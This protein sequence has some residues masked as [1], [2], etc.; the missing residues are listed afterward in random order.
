MGQLLAIALVLV[1]LG[2]VLV[3]LAYRGRRKRGLGSGETIAL[4][5]VN[6]FS[7]RLKLTGRPD[8]IVK[9]DGT[10]IPEEWKSSKR[11]S[12]GHRLQLGTYFLLIE[13]TYGVRPPFGV[14]VLGD[15][16]RVEV[17]NTEKLR[18]TVLAVAEKIRAARRA[19]RAEIPVRQPAAKCAKCGQRVNCG[20]SRE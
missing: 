15:G 6:L 3:G 20:Q 14:V 17:E 7:E 1:L 11:V 10:F 18:S 19:I 8:R 9:Q 4:D 16:S 12:D 2:L 13:E 5:N